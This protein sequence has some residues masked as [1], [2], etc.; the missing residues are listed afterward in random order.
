MFKPKDADKL[1]ESPYMKFQEGDNLFRIL[2][3]PINGYVY[4]QDAEGRIVPRSQ[5]AGPNSKP[6]RV[7]T[8]DD[9]SNE[10]KGGAK[11]FAAMIVWNYTLS[12]IQILEVTQVGIMATMDNYANNKKWGDVT[13]YNFIVNRLKT[14]PLDMDVEYTTTV[15]PKEDLTTEILEA[16]EAKKINIEALYEGGDPFKAPE[17]S[18]DDIKFD[19]NSD[20]KP[21]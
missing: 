21:E 16:Y 5:K 15:E 13:G 9:L 6:V 19:I 8:F 17:V 4:W 14:G 1:K 12:K 20:N 3:D 2:N 18:L 11:P 10:A 7:R